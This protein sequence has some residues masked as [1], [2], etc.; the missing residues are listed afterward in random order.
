M[1]ECHVSIVLSIA[2]FTGA[3]LHGTGQDAPAQLRRTTPPPAPPAGAARQTDTP[4]GVA[5]TEE[6]LREYGELAPTLKGAPEPT[7]RAAIKG[8]TITYDAYQYVTGEV[9]RLA[10]EHRRR[11]KTR[12]ALNQTPV[13][14][15]DDRASLE[16]Q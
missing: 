13:L 3:V 10:A 14:T 4:A 9:E 15:P 7:V 6:M 8:R 16:A 2:L 12:D 11:G 1:R 5:L